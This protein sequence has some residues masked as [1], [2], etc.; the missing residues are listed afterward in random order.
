MIKKNIYFILFD[1]I[2]NF[3]EMG[4]IYF[5]DKILKLVKNNEKQKIIND[6]L[7]VIKK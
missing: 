5:V 1:I 7:D 2:I 4:N 6:N 3:L